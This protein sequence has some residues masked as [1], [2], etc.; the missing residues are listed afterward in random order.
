LPIRIK[1]FRTGP[2]FKFFSTALG[3]KI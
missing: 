1:A 2:S 3:R